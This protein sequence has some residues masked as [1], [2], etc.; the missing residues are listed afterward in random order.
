MKS[1]KRNSKSPLVTQNKP[2]KLKTL[3]EENSLH[4]SFPSNSDESDIESGEEKKETNKPEMTTPEQTKRNQTGNWQIENNEE[5]KLGERVSEFKIKI[6]EN[7]K[8]LQKPLEKS[9]IGIC[10]YISWL[11]YRPKSQKQ[12]HEVFK[13]SLKHIDERLDIINVMK[14]LREIDKLQ[15][16][17][18]DPD[19]Q[20]LF[21][22]MPKPM[23]QLGNVQGRKGENVARLKSLKFVQEEV[24][25]DQL[26]NSIN[27][28][29]DKK[30]KTEIDKKLI[31]MF[32]NESFC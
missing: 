28:L 13:E 30:E 24:Y 3:H 25:E 18:L 27:N 14:K 21:A 6:K 11:L 8:T 15:A 23:A 12:T 32:E 1:E 26:M 7:S 20:I 19:Q 10:E 5:I 31:E 17:L 16:L 2:L 29:R 9:N 22:N 4:L